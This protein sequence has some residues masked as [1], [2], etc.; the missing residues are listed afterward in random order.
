M[1]WAGIHASFCSSDG[2]AWHSHQA[3]QQAEDVSHQCYMCVCAHGGYD[4]CRNGFRMKCRLQLK[5]IQGS[6]CQSSL[7]FGSPWNWSAVSGTQHCIAP[8]ASAAR[9]D[10]TGLSAHTPQMRSISG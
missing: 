9:I 10:V 7:S 2:Q 3:G 1:Y 6:Y 8:L 4:A 5:N